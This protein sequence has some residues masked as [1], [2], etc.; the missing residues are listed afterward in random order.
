MRRHITTRT[1]P[2]GQ[3]YKGACRMCGADNLSIA[4]TNA[5]CPGGRD[6]SV[7]AAVDE[8]TTGKIKSSQKH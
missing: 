7:A 8:A 2:K 1:S 3:P 5:P 6:V 4:E